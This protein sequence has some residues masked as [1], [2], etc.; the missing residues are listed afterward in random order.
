MGNI[1]QNELNCTCAEFLE[2]VYGPRSKPCTEAVKTMFTSVLTRSSTLVKELSVPLRADNGK[3]EVKRVQEMVSRWLWNYDLDERLNPYLLDSA[4]GLVGERTTLA[5]DFSDISK[6]FGGAG[7]EGM[8]EGWDG[9]RGCVAMG[10]DFISVSIVG[11]DHRDALPVYARLGRGRHQKDDL[12]RTAVS[13][14]MERTDGRGWLVFDRGMDDARFIRILKRD[15][16]TA[17]VRI[18]D[19]KRDVFGN[20]RS[21]DATLSDLGFGKAHLNTYRGAIRAEVRCAVGVMQYCAD[22]RSKDAPVHGTRLLVVESRFD[23]RSV[24]LYVVCPDAVIDD[25]ALAWEYAVHAAQAYCDRWQIETSFQTVKQEFRL[26]EARVRKF[27]RL[28]NIFDLCILAYVFTIRFLRNSGRFRK[29]V[30]VLGDNI[31]TLAFR[32]HSLLCGIREL[33]RAGKVRFISGRPRKRI[34][35]D[36]VQLLLAL[37]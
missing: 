21:V 17:V 15:G 33:Y 28:V 25:P 3:G 22:P 32:T 31:E 1:L 13:A 11:A 7:M 27:R 20:G 34:L 36:D 9:S 26:E 8:E 29:I 23:G 14:V 2:R 4:A 18:R 30:K 19:V 6:E 12:L 10:H 35:P 37:E 5:V 24:Y 16:R